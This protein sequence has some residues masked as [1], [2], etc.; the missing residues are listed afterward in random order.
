MN[1]ERIQIALIAGHRWPASETPF[2]TL[3]AGLVAL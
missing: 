2:N 3:N 1:G